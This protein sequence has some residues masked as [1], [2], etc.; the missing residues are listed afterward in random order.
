MPHWNETKWHYPA[1]HLL[2]ADVRAAFEDLI[3]LK[4]DYAQAFHGFE[5]R[6]GL[7][8]QSQQDVPG[9][10]RALAG[11]CVSERSWSW[12]DSP[13]PAV[14]VE[15]RKAMER[16]RHRAWA[17]YLGG[18]DRFNQALLDHREVLRPYRNRL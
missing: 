8:Q 4:Q 2:K 13:V 12:D 3:S 17:H 11:E 5:Y 9:A 10:Y 7:I 16:N 15:F 18:A 1:S 14:E 6:L